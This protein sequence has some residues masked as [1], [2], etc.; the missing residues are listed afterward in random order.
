MK[1]KCNLS[2]KTLVFESVFRLYVQNLR[3][4]LKK[5]NFWPIRDLDVVID[6]ILLKTQKY[7]RN[8]NS[9]Q[10]GLSQTHSHSQ[11][12]IFI[13]MIKAASVSVFDVLGVRQL[14]I[15]CC[16]FIMQSGL[17]HGIN[18]LHKS[19]FQRR[20][21]VLS[22]KQWLY[23][24]LKSRARFQFP[25]WNFSLQRIFPNTSFCLTFLAFSIGFLA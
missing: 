6:S 14:V 24:S 9:D 13:C 12:V 19:I 8:V 20:F 16:I 7:H 25:K 10:L 17:V 4:I 3:Q 15:F 1:V 2:F 21:L 5:M 18:C 22:V 23:V 11:L